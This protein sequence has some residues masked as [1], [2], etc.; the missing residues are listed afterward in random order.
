[1]PSV[2]REQVHARVMS[3][4][5][6]SSHFVWLLADLKF[7]QTED[8]S[9]FAY[10]KGPRVTLVALEPL[11]SEQHVNFEKQWN[12]FREAVAPGAVAFVSIYEPFAEQIRRLGF[13]ILPLGSE[14]WVKLSE[15]FPT[16]NA[17]K[18]VRSARN[19][20]I[21][22]GLTSEEWSFKKILSDENRALLT[23]IYQ[24]WAEPRVL[25]LSGFTLSTDAFAFAE[26]RRYFIVRSK[27]RVEGY[28]VA[29]PVA[30]TRSHYLED[31]ILRRDAARG[32]GEFITLEALIALDKS[33]SHEASLGVVASSGITAKDGQ[34]LP[35]WIRMLFIGLPT[36][37]PFFYNSA[38]QEIYRKRFKP[39]RWARVFL[40]AHPGNSGMSP[41]RLWLGTIRALISALEP[42]FRP[43]LSHVTAPILKWVQKYPLSISVTTL[44]FVFYFILNDSRGRLPGSLL[45]RFGFSPAAPVSEWIYRSIA[46][47]YLYLNATHFYWGTL[48]LAAL[49]IWAERS[50]KRSFIIPF[51]IGAT[52]FDDLLSY[53]I[54]LLPLK[55]FQPEL[56]SAVVQPKDVGGSLIIAS[57]L[58]LQLCQFRKNRE[59]LFCL[60]SLLSILT[61]VWL[62]KLSPVLILN[63]NH[64]IALIAGFTIG[65]LRFEW[66]RII[67]R[68]V[69][70]GKSPVV[71][72]KVKAAEI[73]RGEVDT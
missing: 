19:H 67:S 41:S 4:A 57:L 18:G 14:P 71:N 51:F 56:F 55:H 72:Q 66:T 65:K 49:L 68:R 15:A 43:R 58:G 31:I 34:G 7:Y 20:A 53:V 33:G 63:L 70:G 52:L 21:K 25:Q 45:D 24:D 40:A 23:E 46:N 22:A 39:H 29:S 17:G 12:E 26:S 47:D 48:T 35:A 10:V 73:P 37:L 1:M 11:L 9:I 50:H 61:V 59:L 28:V 5:T 32:A 44:N 54:L 64:F 3:D 36:Y 27:E 8:S 62:A 2:S 60:A 42:K 13:G 69:A 30:K 16:G 6:N 38:G